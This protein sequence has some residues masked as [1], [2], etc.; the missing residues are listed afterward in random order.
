LN[1]WR[2]VQ[3]GKPLARGLEFG[4]TGLHQPF[5]VLM[6]KPRIFGRPTFTY[7][8]AGASVAR[9]YAAFLMKVPDDFAA[10]DSLLYRN[11]KIVVHER[12]GKARELTLAAAPMF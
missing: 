6:S 7:L 12:G 5:P 2:H 8:D 1:L 11:G 4:T 3:D 10:V 9:V